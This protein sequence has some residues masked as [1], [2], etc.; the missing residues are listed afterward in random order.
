VL[1]PR[2]EIILKSIV[3]WYIDHAVPVSSQVL[4][5]DYELGVSSA[6]VRN[7]MAFLEQEGYIIRPHTSSGSVPSDKGYRF[8]VA[9]L[10]DIALP[11]TDQR[12]ISHLFHQVEGRMDEWLSLAATVLARL[13][14]NTAIITV[15]K[16]SDCEFR[17]MELVSIQDSLVLLLVVL[18]GARI[19]Q[20]LFNLE[21]PLSQAELTAI[22]A[23]M[24]AAYIGSSAFQI[25]SKGLDLNS[26]EQ[27][28]RDNLVKIMQTADEQSGGQSYLEGLHFLMNQ[29]EFAHNQRILS[30]MELLEQRAMLGTIMPQPQEGLQVRVVIGS[31]NQAEVAQDCSLVIS[32]Y[33]LPDEASGNI[34]VVGP[35]RM[36]YPRIISAVSYISILLSGLVAELYG[37]NPPA[38]E[39]PGT[40]N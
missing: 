32:R 21:K 29:P 13:S 23:R 9:S 2:T 4:V 28:I 22:S 19:K 8:Y 36:A 33:G 31:E 10:E 26:L 3:N 6:T 1:T 14:Q 24:N 16:P 34:L 15:P 7:E 18:R 20:Q 25:Q 39:N 40:S 38:P 17:H 5:H 30:V 27:T 37:I 11:L 35:T 12:M